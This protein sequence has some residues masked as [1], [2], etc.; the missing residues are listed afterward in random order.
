MCVCMF[1]LSEITYVYAKLYYLATDEL[2][3]SAIMIIICGTGV[4]FLVSYYAVS[5][6]DQYSYVVK[7]QQDM[8]PL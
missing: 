1:N 4:L 5:K 3:S 7:Q 2:L 8:M 6:P